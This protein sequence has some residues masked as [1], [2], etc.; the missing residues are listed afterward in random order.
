MLERAKLIIDTYGEI[1]RPIILRSFAKDSCIASTAITLDVLRRYRIPARAL[2]VEAVAYNAQFVKRVEEEGRWPKDR[3][4]S[5]VWYKESRAHAVFVTSKVHDLATPTSEWVGHVVT[6]VMDR[7]VVDLT[8]DQ[9]G[10]WMM[11]YPELE[12][13]KGI[14]FPAS[15]EFVDGDEWDGIDLPGGGHIDYRRDEENRGYRKARDWTRPR[16]RKGAV[17][18]ILAAMRCQL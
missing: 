15:D 6:L 7:I 8:V 16:R 1:A 10:T 17:K 18:A 4:E 2:P 3:E 13:H 14:A 9:F 11:K 5:A 12:K